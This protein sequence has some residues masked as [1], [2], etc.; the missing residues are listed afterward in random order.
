[1]LYKENQGLLKTRNDCAI[2]ARREYILFID[3][4]GILIERALNKIYGSISMHNIGIIRFDS[5]N[6]FNNTFVKNDL[7]EFFKKEKVLYQ[8]NILKQSFYQNKG[9]LFQY[10][11]NL[12]DKVIKK[13]ISKYNNSIGFI[14]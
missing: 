9:E 10:E 3:Q 6:K 4:N 14:L 8:L 1:M 5:Y 13:I 2:K 12:L 7:K 11:L